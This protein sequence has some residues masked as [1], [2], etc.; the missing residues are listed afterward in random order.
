MRV[1]C[2]TYRTD[3]GAS[4]IEVLLPLALGVTSDALVVDEYGKPRL[5]GGAVEISLS[6]S[7]GIAVLAVAESE[8]G[9]DVEP[10]RAEYVELDRLALERAVGAELATEWMA[11]AGPGVHTG[12]R[13]SEVWTYLE[14]TLKAD[15]RGFLSEP[16][17]NP[18]VLEGWKTVHVDLGDHVACV[19]AREMPA[20]EVVHHP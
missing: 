4:G 17:D 18:D 11:G 19:A 1:V 14:A 15:G 5:A 13:F 8:V 20:V 10:V 6:W 2:H 7:P 16:R 9:I 12:R 3:G